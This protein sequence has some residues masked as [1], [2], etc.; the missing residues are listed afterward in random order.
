M[1]LVVIFL[2]FAIVA[3]VAA[4]AAP[5][6]ELSDTL[7]DMRAQD[8]GMLL[9]QRERML[10]QMLVHDRALAAYWAQYVHG[11]APSAARARLHHK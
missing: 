4:S 7:Q 8:L 3:P 1:K 10:A 9:T 6:N 11:V 2:L 5:L